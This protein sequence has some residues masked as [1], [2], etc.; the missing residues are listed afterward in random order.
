MRFCRG[1]SL[2]D[3]FAECH[4]RIREPC[5]WITCFRVNSAHIAASLPYKNHARSRLGFGNG[6][7]CKYPQGE[8]G[9]P[10]WLLYGKPTSELY[11]LCESS[12]KCHLD[13]STASQGRKTAFES[14]LR[15][16][17]FGS[18]S[19]RLRQKGVLGYPDT[20]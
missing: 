11:H 16:R 4:S 15:P 19:R 20:G 14:L 8:V 12:F 17:R 18:S 9:S 13:E 2:P 3:W 10:Y 5:H 1:R 6:S 7:C